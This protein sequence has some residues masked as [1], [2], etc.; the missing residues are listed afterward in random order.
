VRFVID[1]QPFA[2]CGCRLIDQGPDQRLTDALP[3]V[4]AVD[5]GVQYERVRPAVPAGVH[6]PDQGVVFEGT[7]PG[8]AVMLKTLRPWLGSAA[9]IAEGAS[10]QL[11]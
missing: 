7:D 11:G 4:I 5:D 3:P 8:Q 2:A 1:V 9:P 10:V 6:K